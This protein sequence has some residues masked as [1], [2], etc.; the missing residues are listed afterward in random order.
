M[1]SSMTPSIRGG[2]VK[3]D[4]TLDISHAMATIKNVDYEIDEALWDSAIEMRDILLNEIVPYPPELPNQIYWRTL[5]LLLGYRFERRH[6]KLAHSTYVQMKI[7]NRTPYLK[8]V[9][10]EDTQAMIHRNRHKTAEEVLNEQYDRLLS[11][12]QRNLNRRVSRA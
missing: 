4:V 10:L 9:K 3:L 8:W 12:W 7:F 5:K 6:R 11:V 1:K 2:G